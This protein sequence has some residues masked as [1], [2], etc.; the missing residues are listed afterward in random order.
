MKHFIPFISAIITSLVGA[1][2]TKG[3][4]PEENFGIR[5][6]IVSMVFFLI[7]FPVYII[8]GHFLNQTII[9]EGLDS[10]DNLRRFLLGFSKHEI[11]RWEYGDFDDNGASEAFA[12]IVGADGKHHLWYI[13]MQGAVEIDSIDSGSIT[14]VI[15]ID[16]RSFIVWKNDYQYTTE[17]SACIGVKKGQWYKLDLYG[18]DFI[19]DSS[20]DVY[21]ASPIF[22]YE[23]EFVRYT[24]CAFD[25]ATLELIET[26]SYYK[27]K[28]T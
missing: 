8:L 10:E 13:S 1:F 6:I 22:T 4:K 3:E 18:I 9:V 23:G 15:H 19:Q 12:E 17:I 5:L 27:E 24:L 16:G 20:G 28:K 21:V 25:E 7:S 26:E 2:I 11:A 14:R